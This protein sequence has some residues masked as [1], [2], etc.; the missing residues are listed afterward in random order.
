MLLNGML[1]GNAHPTVYHRFWRFQNPYFSNIRPSNRDNDTINPVTDYVAMKQLPA[2]EETIAQRYRILA[3]LAEGGS[4][5]TYL[6][7]ILNT[8][9]RVVLKALSLRHI[10]D[11]KAIER[12][13]RE[14]QVLAQLNHSEIPRYLDYFY[15]DTPSDR[16]CK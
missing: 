5:I 13:E 11:G 4:G 15:Q 7:E 16:T 14:A 12:F 8:G 10:H 2:R 1:V 3:P 6:G 9:E